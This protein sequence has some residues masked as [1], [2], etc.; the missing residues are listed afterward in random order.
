MKIYNHFPLKKQI[1]K[2]FKPIAT[3]ILLFAFIN[4]ALAF[5]TSPIL[6]DRKKMD[7]RI[8]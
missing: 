8:L 6:N 1:A 4:S 5:G 2:V 7:F 3:I